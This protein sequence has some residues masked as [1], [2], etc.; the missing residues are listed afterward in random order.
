MKLNRPFARVTGT[1]VTGV[2][3][4]AAVN[5]GKRLLGAG[6]LRRGAVTATAWGLRG[7]RT[8]EVGAETARLNAAD[9]LAEARERVGEQA[10]APGQNDGEH[11]H[12]H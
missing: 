8:A 10:A 7:L 6:V 4:V 1:L 2:V 3:G 11:A 9:V 5:T 12:E